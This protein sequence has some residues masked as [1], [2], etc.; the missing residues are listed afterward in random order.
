VLHESGVDLWVSGDARAEMG[1]VLVKASEG[2]TRKRLTRGVAVTAM[3]LS[4]HFSRLTTHKAGL[5]SPTCLFPTFTKVQI[6]DGKARP[7]SAL[8][9]ACSPE[10][11]EAV[12]K[13]EWVP[14]CT[15]YAHRPAGR[16]IMDFA[17]DPYSMMSRITW[18]KDEPSHSAV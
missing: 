3:G 5:Q 6:N 2:E 11:W 9:K 16:E 8:R 18:Y 1:D 4:P 13:L 17:L 10:E 14:E 12:Q 7:R 15:G